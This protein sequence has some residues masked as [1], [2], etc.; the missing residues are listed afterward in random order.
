MYGKTSGALHGAGAGPARAGVL[1]GEVLAAARE[2]L[3]PLPGRAA[4]VLQLAALADPGETEVLELAGWADP[5]AEAY[6][7]RSGP[8]PAWLGVLDEYAEHLLLADEASGAWPA[9]PRSSSTWPTPPRT[10]PVRGWPPVSN[11][12][13]PAA[14][15]R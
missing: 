5:R 14:R 10:P 7:F 12:S 9:P 6:F 8:A 15:A 1:Y 11:S 2:L 4:R 13:P 3:V